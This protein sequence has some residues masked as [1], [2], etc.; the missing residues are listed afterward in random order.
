MNMYSLPTEIL[1][2]IGK[3]D[4]STYRGMLAIP[5]FARGVTV[6]YRLDAM[7]AAKYNYIPAIRPVVRYFGRVTT[8]REKN[9]M[10]YAL[11]SEVQGFIGI[12][13]RDGKFADVSFNK[14]GYA[15]T[16]VNKL[17][18][19]NDGYRSFPRSKLE[20]ISEQGKCI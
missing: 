11:S 6:G 19:Y 12:R 5:K 13:F 7:V 2:E 16:T 3:T 14:S 9:G 4:K 20:H 17:I 10:S 15:C 8:Y 1:L 18:A